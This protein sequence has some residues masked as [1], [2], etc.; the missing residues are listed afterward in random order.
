M[1]DKMQERRRSERYFSDLKVYFDTPYKIN[2]KIEILP[3]FKVKEKVDGLTQNVSTE[4]LC[5]ISDKSFKEGDGAHVILHVPRIR[6]LAK[7]E[8]E[9][10]WCRR[11]AEEE[12][13]TIGDFVTGV[14]VVML[15]GESVFQSIHFNRYR[16]REWSNLLEQVFGDQ[17]LPE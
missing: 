4:G 16:Q 2:T 11:S 12:E 13:K 14:R 7:L 1:K 8:A 15:N 5:F 10:R 3:D 17:K 6:K 9:V